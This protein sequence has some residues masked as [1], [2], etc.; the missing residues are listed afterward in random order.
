MM[1]KIKNNLSN[2]LGIYCELSFRP[3]GE[4]SIK[5]KDFSVEDSLEMTTEIYL[6]VSY[7]GQAQKK[8]WRN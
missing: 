5:A 1:S 4:I 7:S 8:F 3:R 2:C 6:T